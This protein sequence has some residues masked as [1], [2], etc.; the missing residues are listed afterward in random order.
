MKNW[1]RVTSASFLTALVA[2]GNVVPS[3]AATTDNSISQREKE[4]AALARAVAS[5][6]MVLLKNDE[7]ALPIKG[8]NIVT[9]PKTSN[10][11]RVVDMPDFIVDELRNYMDHL[12]KVGDDDYFMKWIEDARKAELKELEFMD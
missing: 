7:N 12:Y 1:R 4:N 11:I 10:S 5:E 6:G 2:I 9:D 3:M 8:K